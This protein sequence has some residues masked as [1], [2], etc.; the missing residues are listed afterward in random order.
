[1]PPY[2]SRLCKAEKLFWLQLEAAVAGAGRALPEPVQRAGHQDNGQDA[3]SVSIFYSASSFLL[4]LHN[5]TL[6]S[7]ACMSGCDCEGLNET[8]TV[9]IRRGQ[10]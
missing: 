10:Y 1:M 3:V 2:S 6:S 5:R 4:G 7:I 9:K 8:Q